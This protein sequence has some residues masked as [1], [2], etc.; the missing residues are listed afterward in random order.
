MTF[1]SF[2]NAKFGIVSKSVFFCKIFRSNF[3]GTFK[4]HVL[5]DMSQPCFAINLIGTTGADHYHP[6]KNRNLRPINQQS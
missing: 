2:I 1:P 3:L 6:R 4:C 5:K